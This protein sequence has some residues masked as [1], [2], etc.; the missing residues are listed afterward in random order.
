MRRGQKLL[1]IVAADDDAEKLLRAMVG[2]GFPATKIGSTGGFLRRGNSTIMSGVDST[3]VDA[4]LEIVQEIC[5]PRSALIP[6][7]LLPVMGDAVPFTDPME[8][9]I[10][11]AVAFVLNVERFEKI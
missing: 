8:V 1:I 7:Q 9:R 6:L 10:G 2:A 5:K 3:E 4:V 11:G